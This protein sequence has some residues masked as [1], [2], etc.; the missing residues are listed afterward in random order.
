MELEKRV[1]ERSVDLQKSE[2]KALELAAK[3]EAANQAK[4]IFIGNMS[5][6]LRSPLNAVIGFSQLMMR[7]NNLPL[8]HYENASIINRSGDYL[9]TLINNILDLSKIEA[10]KTTLNI[11]NFDLEHL[12]GE[13]EDMLQLRAAEAGLILSLVQARD[14]PSYI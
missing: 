2:A 3:S 5:N 8:E 6:E 12:L 14:L 9:L 4:S 11:S 1:L 10:G 13:V 7:T